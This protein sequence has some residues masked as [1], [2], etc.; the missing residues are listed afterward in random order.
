MLLSFKQGT[1]MEFQERRLSSLLDM[2]LIQTLMR[3]LSI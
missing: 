3:K 1:V 2:V